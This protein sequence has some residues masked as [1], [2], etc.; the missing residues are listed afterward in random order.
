LTD[1]LRSQT[2]LGQETLVEIEMQEKEEEEAVF[3][4]VVNTKGGII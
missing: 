2:T 3:I 1:N 4:S